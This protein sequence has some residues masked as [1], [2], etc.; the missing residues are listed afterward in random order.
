MHLHLN[1]QSAS[2]TVI[3]R[4]I[5]YSPAK[6]N[7]DLAVESFPFTNKYEGREENYRDLTKHSWNPVISPFCFPYSVSWQK[8]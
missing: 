2:K 6:M 3:I 8:D 4:L 1:I 5:K 7:H